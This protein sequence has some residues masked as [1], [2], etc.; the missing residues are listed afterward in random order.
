MNTVRHYHA[1]GLLDLPQRLHNG[2]KQYQVSHLVRLI[3]LR[4]LAELGVPLA[5]IE[6]VDT[7]QPSA[8]RSVDAELEADIER[9][10]RARSDVAAILRENA[11][12]DTP[13]GFEAIAARMSGADRSLVHILARLSGPDDRAHL[14]AM[15]AAEPAEARRRF[16]DLLPDATEATRESLAALLAS[17]GPHWRSPEA[18]PPRA[19]APLQTAV[20]ELYR[21]V[22]RDV[23]R[24]ASSMV[25]RSGAPGVVDSSRAEPATATVSAPGGPSRSR[26][27]R[28]AG[29]HSSGRRQHRAP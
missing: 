6:E 4:R 10:Q 9:L 8:L 1:V 28:H 29:E 15:V 2:Y 27:H 25:S 19:R 20:A 3:R 14:L 17:N 18:A 16:D 11:P 7:R 23:L 21:P 13:H 26:R 24:R 22:Q 5:R 12:P